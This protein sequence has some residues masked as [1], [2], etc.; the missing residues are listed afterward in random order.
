MKIAFF[1]LDK[2][3]IA[4]NS[5]KL[6]LKRQWDNKKISTLVMLKASFWLTKYNFGLSNLEEM[7]DKSLYLIKGYKHQDIAL[8]TKEFYEQSIKNLYRPKALQKVKEHKKNGDIIALL[9]SSFD[10]LSRLVQE[11]LQLDY[12]LCSTLEIDNNG[13]YTGKSI[14]PLCFGKNKIIFAQN[15]CNK[16]NINLSDCIFYTDSATD[17]PMLLAVKNPI[18]IN[19]DPR[20]KKVAYKNKWPILDWGNP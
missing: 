17:L 5:A 2:T 19:P 8:E 6:W 10:D 15:L 13:Y 18:A 7:M 14:G 12:R 9:T 20:L 3:L 16:L 1:D 11:E 4:E